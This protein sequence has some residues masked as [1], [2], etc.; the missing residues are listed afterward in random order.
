MGIPEAELEQN[1]SDVVLAISEQEDGLGSTM[2]QC[3]TA[4]CQVLEP[5]CHST[6]AIQ[7]S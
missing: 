3:L 7:I 4:L 2:S 1:A 6:G 5:A